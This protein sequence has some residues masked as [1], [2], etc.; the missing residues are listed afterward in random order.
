[1]NGKAERFIQ[2]LL[3]EWAY[4]TAYA[5]SR[6]RRR[7]LRPWLRYYNRERPHASLVYGTP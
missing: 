6:T 2:T 4:A 3:R 5:D 1:M 7:E